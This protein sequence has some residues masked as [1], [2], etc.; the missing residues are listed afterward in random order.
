[1]NEEAIERLALYFGSEGTRQAWLARQAL[2]RSQPGDAALARSLRAEL[3]RAVRPDGT[4]S[5]G[6]VPTIWR[7]H[8][9]LDLGEP[10]ESPALTA[11]L[12]WL[13]DL[14]D[15][16][17]AFHDGCDRVRHSRRLCHHFIAGFFAPAPPGQRLA[18]VTLPTGKVFRV[19][20]A[21]R[22]AISCLALR[23]A[24]RAGYGDRPSVKRHLQSLGQIAEQWTEWNGYFAPDTIVAG[25]HALALGGPEYGDAVDGAVGLITTNQGIEGEWPN[26]DLF[27][28]LDALQAAGTV[29][30]QVTVRRA[31]TAL[32]SRQRADGTFGSMAQQERALIGL[33]ALLWAARS[34]A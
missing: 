28:V 33:R 15:R 14:Q 34:P 9:L 2:G 22:F 31:S 20:P 17:G 23:A 11:S 21:A 7:M 29:E 13:L 4:V 27:Q 8:E 19:E 6:A 26:A 3:A 1:M 25:L 16:P 10:E 30:A 32:G 12:G 5:G 18:P 24:L